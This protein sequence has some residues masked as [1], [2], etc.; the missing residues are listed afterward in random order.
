MV[1]QVGINGFGRIGR[2]VLRASLARE[3]IE[4]VAV[5]DPF[6]STEYMKYQFKYDSS[7][8]TF[9][10]T[11]ECDEEG[12]FLIINGKKIKT[13]HMKNP[14]DIPW[15][16]NGVE[17][18]AECTGIFKTIE[19]ASAHLNGSKPAKKV[20]ISAP[21]SDAPM[22][23]VGVNHEKYSKDMTVFSNASCTTNAL[24]P[25]TKVINDEFGIA[26]GLMTTIHAVTSTQN[27]VDGPTKG[28]KAKWRSGRGAYQNIIPASTGAAKAV[29]KVIPEVEGKLTGMAFRVPVPTGS[30]ID[31]TFRTEKECSYDDIKKAMRNA[32]QGELKGILGYTE[33]P[34]VS[35]DIVGDSRSSIFDA[36][37][38]LAVGT[39]FF[40]VVSWYDNEW[41][42]SN[43]LCDLLIIAAKVDGYGQSYKGRSRL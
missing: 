36:A 1:V 8:G 25:I 28:G 30:V 3:E 5:N 33:E 4:V 43:R 35:Q 2:L 41:G 39:R 9:M 31:L 20:C 42:Y 12:G 13:Y 17:Y 10:Q 22:F 14:S 32:S 7:Q 29:G 11:V 16:D 26:E 40:K 34:I 27:S 38:G 18:V 37:A 21:S 6:V 15:G 24:A 19:K 23:V